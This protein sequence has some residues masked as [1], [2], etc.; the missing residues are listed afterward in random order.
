MDS[1]LKMASVLFYP[2]FVR[3]LV[4]KCSLKIPPLQLDDL[5]IVSLLL[6]TQTLH[7]E[8][9]LAD[10]QIMCPITSSLF[11]IGNRTAEY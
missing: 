11:D 6:L 9:S 10:L 7:R 2:F 4:A 5:L 3:F 1:C 8:F